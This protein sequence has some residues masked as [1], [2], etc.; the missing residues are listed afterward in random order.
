MSIRWHLSN[1]QLAG[2]RAGGLLLLLGSGAA[3]FWGRTSEWMTLIY[4]AV[5]AALPL[6]WPQFFGRWRIVLGLV[7]VAAAPAG[8]ARFVDLSSGA[9]PWLEPVLLGQLTAWL[10]LPA[11]LALLLWRRRAAA[12][13]TLL[14]MAL[15]PVASILVMQSG[16]YPT[17]L[18]EPVIL[19]PVA[20]L[21]RLM[22]LWLMM[23]SCCLGPLFFGATLVWLI[24]REA[25]GKA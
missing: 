4:L 18:T 6:L 5:A 25:Q 7:L 1:R 11:T 24:V 20:G 8:L 14:G 19:N 13:V 9:S 15:M 17:S 16:A 2:L 12:A 21:A 23:A 10:M 3:V 22:P